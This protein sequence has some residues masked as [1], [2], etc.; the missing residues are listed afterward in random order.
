MEAIKVIQY[1]VSRAGR[2]VILFIVLMAGCLGLSAQPV[3]KNYTVKNGRMFI[4]LGKMMK[5]PSLDSFISQ[6]D[7]KDLALKELIR[8]GFKDSLSRQ[9]WKVEID[10]Q[11]IIVISKP[12]FGMEDLKDPVSRLQL[13]VAKD[14]FDARFPAVSN[15]VLFGYN[16]FRNKSPFHVDDSLVRFYLRGYTQARKV[17][18]AGSFNNWDP[19]TLAMTLT[20]SGWI[21]QVK[22]GPGKYWYKFIVDGNWMPDNDNRLSE[23]DGMGNTNSVFFKTNF[24]F[25][26]IGHENA[27]RVTVAGSFNGWNGN[28]LQMNRAPSGWELPLYLADGTHTYRF[29]ADGNWFADPANPDKFPNEYG[30]FNSVIRL[31]KPHLFLLEGFADAKKVVLSGSFNGWRT[32]E[33]FLKKTSVGWEL[34]Y[35]LGPGNYEY[36]YLVDGKKEVKQEAPGGKQGNFYFVIGPNY[37]FRL[38]G[39]PNARAVYLA[40]DFNG[41]SPNTFA[42]HKDGDDWV[43]AVHLSNGKHLYKFVVDGKWII[44]PSN[45]LWEQ[46]EQHTGNSVI[47]IG[48]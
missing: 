48:K 41:W 40:G 7:L 18:L 45:K 39:Y 35:T 22:L 2:L 24:V 29:I 21:A 4:T 12:L 5:E 23:N 36:Y 33:L 30:D 13:G 16:R 10:N 26:L 6:F 1:H 28:E 42:M 8:K 46:N 17:T 20:D 34:P 38:K 11:E 14:D 43:L 27:K 9:G 25:K 19:S 37:N 44:D 31:G 15:T 47:W 32:D 3:I